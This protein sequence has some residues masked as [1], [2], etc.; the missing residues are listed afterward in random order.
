MTAP[1]SH[2]CSR[3]TKLPPPTPCVCTLFYSG[4]LSAVLGSLLS[5]SRSSKI[6]PF[7]DRLIA[8]SHPAL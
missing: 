3:S 1:V 4:A 8:S 2:L 5:F 6:V 7:V